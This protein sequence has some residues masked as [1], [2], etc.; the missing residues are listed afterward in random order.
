MFKVAL[1]D[2]H[3]ESLAGTQALLK[4][5]LV[6]HPKYYGD[7]HS[8]SAPDKLLSTLEAGSLFDIYLLD[9]VMPAIDGIKLAREIRSRDKQSSIIY[10]TSSPDYAVQSYSVQALHY[11]LKPVNAEDF[12]DA[13]TRAVTHWENNKGRIFPLRTKGGAE[14]IHV[15]SMVY[16]EYRN[17]RLYANMMDGRTVESV[18]MRE[19]F[20]HLL[21][22][23]LAEPGLLKVGASYLVNF[24]YIRKVESKNIL[25]ATGQML[26]LPRTMATEVKKKFM[27]FLLRGGNMK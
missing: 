15:S 27:E 8:F 10:L 20:D 2:D 13:M 12:S 19:S 18:S 4:D 25:L 14:V 7:I 5:Y 16:I 17:H 21:G 23:L 6:K 9:I 24:H 3:R 11:L 1:C 26:P 22:D